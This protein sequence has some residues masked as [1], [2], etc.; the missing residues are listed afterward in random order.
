MRSAK[1]DANQPEIVEALRAVG[2]RVTL[3]HRLGDGFTDLFAFVPWT[4]QIHVLE[5]KVP[6]GKLTKLEQKWHDMHADCDYVHIVE[7]IAEAFCAVG[8]TV[9]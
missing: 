4:G 7:S 8:A 5:V 9:I 6:G 1:S 3:T 2:V